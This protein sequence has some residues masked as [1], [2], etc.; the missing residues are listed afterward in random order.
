M[1]TEKK[2]SE[3]DLKIGIYPRTDK[4]SQDNLPQPFVSTE[5]RN[6]KLNSPFKDLKETNIQ[7]LSPSLSVK[8]NFVLNSKRSEKGY[9][10]W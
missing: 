4:G 3:R 7:T 10:D 1:K 6:V 9:R 8:N 5:A 2:Y